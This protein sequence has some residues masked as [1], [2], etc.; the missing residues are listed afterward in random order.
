MRSLNFIGAVVAQKFTPPRRNYVPVFGAN[1]FFVT[2]LA[3]K[4]DEIALA[5][6][7]NLWALTYAHSPNTD[8]R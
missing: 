4:T 3:Q 7:E 5:K 8:G 2:S 1:V 6:R